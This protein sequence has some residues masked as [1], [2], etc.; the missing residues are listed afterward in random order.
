L[1]QT[2]GRQGHARLPS[3]AP[4]GARGLK[5]GLVRVRERGAWI[6]TMELPELLSTKKVAPRAGRVD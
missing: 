4:R 5:L 3:R 6:E 2:F 1:K